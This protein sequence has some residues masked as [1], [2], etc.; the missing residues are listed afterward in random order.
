MLRAALCALGAGLAFSASA[1]N[2]VG[3]GFGGGHAALP[4]L[5]AAYLGTPVT[6]TPDKT[7]NTSFKLYAGHQFT[8]NWGVEAGVAE[9]GDGYSARTTVSGAP[10][11]SPSGSLATRYVAATAT[12]PLE[13]RFSL[14]GKIGIAANEFSSHGACL[15]IFPP[16]CIVPRSGSHTGLMAGVGV[17]Y[18]VAPKLGLRLEYEDYGKMSSD[19][20]WGTGDSGAIKA[21]SWYLGAQYL[22]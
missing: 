12:L 3:I 22:F 6:A 4:S 10:A 16:G 17:Q 18:R 7:D 5:D 8:H 14:F 15:A 1:Q 19:D 20:V 13:T 21:N 9:L 2:Y 11:G